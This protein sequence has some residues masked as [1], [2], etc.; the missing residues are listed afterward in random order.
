MKNLETELKQLIVDTLEL[1]WIKPTDIVSE[2]PL[3]GAGLGLDSIDALEI[4]VA[5]KKKYN[6]QINTDSTE[7][8]TFFASIKNLASFVESQLKNNV[9]N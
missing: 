2:D 7:L 6:I 8:V 1:D 3:F 5:L 9:S 4:G